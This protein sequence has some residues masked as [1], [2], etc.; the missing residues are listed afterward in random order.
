L[1]LHQVKRV[2]TKER[3]RALLIF[4]HGNAP[5]SPTPSGCGVGLTIGRAAFISSCKQTSQYSLEK[6]CF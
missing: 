4:R 1:M 6:M 5:S 2:I 3:H